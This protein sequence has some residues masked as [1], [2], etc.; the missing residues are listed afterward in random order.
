MAAFFEARLEPENGDA[1]SL[2]VPETRIDIKLNDGTGTGTV[3]GIV[4]DS[5]GKP[6]AEAVVQLA[7]NRFEPV[8]GCLT[9]P[10]GSFVFRDIPAKT[11]YWLYAGG[12]GFKVFD[13]P[14]F[15]LL[16]N[17]EIK[18]HIRLCHDGGNHQA[19]LAGNITIGNDQ[20]A[21]LSAILVFR[22][23]DKTLD[24]HSLN[25]CDESGRYLVTNLEP[26]AYLV[27]IISESCP[28]VIQ[29]LQIGQRD[30]LIKLDFDLSGPHAHH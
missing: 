19:C 20:A 1:S 2:L 26:G 25:F 27:R 29:H 18:H 14:P 16:E 30:K 13:S 17:Q 12:K 24:Y 23:A 5:S 7:K 15:F 6:I 4:T 3:R 22:L 28:P 11:Q 21:T 8:A 9:C 10:D